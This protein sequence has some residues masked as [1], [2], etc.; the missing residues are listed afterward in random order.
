MPAVLALAAML[1]G[2]C[3]PAR[4]QKRG[5]P[6]GPPASAS[7]SGLTDRHPVAT[8]QPAAQQPD[9]PLLLLEDSPEPAAANQVGADN[10]RCLVCHL[11]FEAEKLT[12]VHARGQVGC[13]KCHGASDAHIADESWASGGRGTPPDVMFTKAQVNPFCLGCH[14]REKIQHDAHQPFFAGTSPEKHCTDCHGQHRMP[15]RRCHWK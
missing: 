8:D 5:A 13:E 6:A 4:V 2:G 1:S 14:V 7:Q 11:N 3:E 15:V 9:A 10:S 12:R